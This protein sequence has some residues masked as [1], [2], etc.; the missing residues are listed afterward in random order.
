MV[1]GIDL[2]VLDSEDAVKESRLHT[3]LG[4]PQ[5]QISTLAHQNK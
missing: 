1:H 5:D 4:G 2:N 3:N